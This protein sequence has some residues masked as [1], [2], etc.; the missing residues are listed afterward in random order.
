MMWFKRTIL[1]S[2]VAIMPLVV[3]A[4]I[5]LFIEHAALA[6]Q[7]ERIESEIFRTIDRIDNR[8]DRIERKLDERNK[9]NR[10]PL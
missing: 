9:R 1:T 4:L 3:G 6:V 10:R 7:V 8:L 2:I 5:N